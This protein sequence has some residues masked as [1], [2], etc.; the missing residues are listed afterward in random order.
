MSSASR[1][2]A[3]FFAGGAKGALDFDTYTKK[4][5]IAT[6]RDDAIA[7]RQMALAKYTTGA[8]A[9]RQETQITSTE[10]LA[11]AQIASREKIAT[12]GVESTEAG[13]TAQVA[14]NIR[15][16]ALQPSGWVDD[17]GTAIT[18]EQFKTATPKQK[19]T[20]KSPKAQAKILSD[21]KKAE[22]ILEHQNAVI[23]KK[24]QSGNS[25]VAGP[26]DL[27][28][29]M[30]N[31]EKAFLFEDGE[32]NAS[33]K[34]KVVQRMLEIGWTGPLLGGKPAPI[35]TGLSLVD[36]IDSKMKKKLGTQ[37]T[38]SAVDRKRPPSTVQT[39]ALDIPGEWEQTPL[40]KAE[41]AVKSIP[42]ALKRSEVTNV[43]ALE[44]LEKG[45]TRGSLLPGVGT[46]KR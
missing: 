39:G 9:D 28:K 8:A 41:A 7:K 12:A 17:T 27:Q 43:E 34:Q 21:I 18:K 42:G 45:R 32:S 46:F 2:L 14:E 40:G 25:T 29:T 3:G 11:E 10:K 33:K 35:K 30:E 16:E 15:R 1:A 38:V 31:M 37:A 23:L 5:A 6:R 4:E 20:W 13:R 36:S 26:K 44:R 24:I 19:K 22:K